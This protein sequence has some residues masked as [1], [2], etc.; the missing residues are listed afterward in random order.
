MHGKRRTWS[1]HWALSDV[2]IW[3]LMQL[4]PVTVKGNIVTPSEVTK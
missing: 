1:E 4:L 2:E 3:A